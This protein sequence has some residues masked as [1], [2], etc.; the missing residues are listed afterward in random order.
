M[1]SPVITFAVIA[2]VIVFVFQ[3]VLML[4]ALASAVAPQPRVVAAQPAVP[5]APAAQVTTTAPAASTSPASTAPSTT[6]PSSTTVA[7]QPPAI[8]PVVPAVPAVPKATA[9]KAPAPAPKPSCDPNYSGCVP[10]DSDVDCAGGS[11]NGPSY[12]R[13]PIRVLGSDIYDLDRDGDGIACE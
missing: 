3:A 8:A 2:G 4:S 1:K 12:V 11:G 9:P 10:I 5:V 7:T 13:G 6:T